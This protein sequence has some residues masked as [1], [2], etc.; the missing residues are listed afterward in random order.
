MTR[1]QKPNHETH[2]MYERRVAT[3]E[4]NMNLRKTI[5]GVIVAVLIFTTHTSAQNISR[6][7]LGRPALLIDMPGDPASGGVAWAEKNS[8]SFLPNAWSAE[9]GGVR[10]EV[11][12][13][14]TSKDPAALLAETGQKLNAQF[15][16]QRQGKLSGRDVVSFANSQRMVTVIGSDGGVMSGAS[17]IV[18][19]TYK[20]PEGQTLAATLFDSIKVEREGN[21]H[22]A[23]RSMGYTFLA[24]ELPFE[25]LT[26]AKSTDSGGTKRYE[27]SFDGMDVRVTNETPGEGMVFEKENTLRDIAEGERSMAGVTDFKYTRTKYKLGERDGEMITK[28]FKRGYRNY[29]IYDIAFI[30]KRSAVTVSIQIDPTRTDHQNITERILR[31]M[32]PTINTIYGWKTYAVGNKGLY[33]D[34]P[35]APSAP[36]QMNAVTI[37]ESSAPLAPVEIRE[38]EVGFPGAHDPDFSAKQYFEMQQAL[39]QKANFQF[40]SMEKLLIDGME[41]RLVKATWKNGDRNNFR[42]ILTIYGYETQWIIDMLAT[43]DNVEYLERVMQ[44]VRVKVGFPQRELRQTFGSMGVSFL[45][46]DKRFEPKVTQDPNDPDFTREESATAQVGDTIVAVYEMNF[47]NATLDATDARGKVYMDGFLRGLSKSANIEIT[48]KQR[49]SFPVNIDGI[50]GRHLIYDL[51]TNVKRQGTVIQADF[52]MLKQDK[53]LWT[54]CVITNFDGGLAARYNRARILNS[55]RVGM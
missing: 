33:V 44:S 8:Y 18:M 55:L 14:Y 51:G 30:E 12:R 25:L 4:Q 1:D 50:E 6:W 40:Q 15:T 21:R 22:W 53:K 17:W 54:V 49:D 37:Y 3:N 39:N 10:L 27:S 29:R 13:V 43:Q 38:L 28:D 11:A 34:L 45:V 42:Q 32:K 26:Q 48:A 41:A 31:S 7:A 46:G 20:D 23:L 2:E 35:V 16:A 47:K 36:K 24:A 9:G 52:V 19:A 5:F